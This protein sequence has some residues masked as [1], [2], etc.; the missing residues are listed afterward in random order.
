M[1]DR[2]RNHMQKP[3]IAIRAPSHKNAV[4]AFAFILTL[5]IGLFMLA[6]AALA[7]VPDNIQAIRQQ[8]L[9]LVNRER[10]ERNLAPLQLGENLI[11]AAQTHAED[12]FNRGYY[13]HE[14]PEGETVQDRYLEAGG[15]RWQLVAENI[16]R[17]GGCTPPVDAEAVERLHQGW[18]NSPPHRE[19]ILNPSLNTFGYGLAIGPDRG[20]YA[21]Q[22][23]AG[24]GAPRNLQPN[25]QA[26]AL[27]PE[28][29]AERATQAINRVRR[30]AGV[31]ALESSQALSEAA[32]QLLPPEQSED[33]SLASSAGLFAALP[34]QE[35][36]QWRALSVI[37]GACGGC[38]TTSTAADVRF[39]QNQWSD[40]PQH[41]GQLLD[42]GLTHL[43]FAMRA[44]GEGRKVAVLV[45]GQYR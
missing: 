26:E 11:E 41:R 17:C 10:R 40:N 23:F 36:G 14:S 25:E 16:A 31:P 22:T 21:V 42:P 1:I 43:G 4:T 44:N 39:F 33:F 5:L 3:Q 13:A 37:A 9:D 35:Q 2:A 45:L 6:Q 30:R 27:S 29:Q 28:Q 7:A 12:M 19:A 38:G 34:A 18:M 24:P 8:A 15:S 20:L 32:R